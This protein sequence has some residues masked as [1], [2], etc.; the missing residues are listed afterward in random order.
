MSG[1]CWV[2]FRSLLW[3]EYRSLRLKNSWIIVIFQSVLMENNINVL[4][5]KFYIEMS[6]QELLSVETSTAYV[7]ASGICSELISIN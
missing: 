4:I 7:V 2:S 5:S 6:L 3:F 1:Y